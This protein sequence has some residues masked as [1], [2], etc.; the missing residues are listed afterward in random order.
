MTAGAE[1]KPVSASH[2]TLTQLMEMDEFQHEDRVLILF[3]EGALDRI[4]Q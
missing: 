4:A 3:G 2:V 1:P